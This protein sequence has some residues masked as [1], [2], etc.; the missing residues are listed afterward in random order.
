MERQVIPGTFRR[1]LPW[2]IP[3]LL[4]LSW[5]F[6]STA[7]WL[8]T[9]ILPAPLEVAASLFRLAGTGELWANIKVS[10]LRA[11]AGFLIG[12]AVGLTL[13]FLTATSGRLEIL[14]DSSLQMFR[15]IPHLAL[16]PLVIIWFG[17]GERA[18]I[19]LIV[20]GVMFPIYLNTFHGIRS[21]DRQLVN[22]ARVYGLN[23]LQLWRQVILPGALSSILVGVRFSL[24]VMWMTLIV[25]ETIAASSGIGYMATNARELMQTDVMV[26]SILLYALLG[27]LA[28]V[29]ARMLERRWLAW[30][31]EFLKAGSC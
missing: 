30:K 23:R 26:L 8:N 3:C 16:I 13:G 1:L 24:G 17:I 5:Q 22:M 9:R 11:G 20:C 25:A 27:K 4:L 2:L 29:C 31:P 18:K 15:T 12:A 7:G 21:V 6:C 10:C 14:L 28:D 19:F